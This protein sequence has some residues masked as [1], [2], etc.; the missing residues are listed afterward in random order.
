MLCS[1][2]EGKKP[3]QSGLRRVC[4]R[5]FQ[6]RH[7]QREVTFHTEWFEEVHT[8]EEQAR[9]LLCTGGKEEEAARHTHRLKACA[10]PPPDSNN[11]SWAQT[12][13]EEV[14]PLSLKN[15]LAITSASGQQLL[16]LHHLH[17]ITS[18]TVHHQFKI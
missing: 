2:Q 5:T 7:L 1:N 10:G 18:L 14:H 9:P 11:G 3:L 4:Q 8:R 13:C 6:R 16:L 17:E 12:D 15:Y